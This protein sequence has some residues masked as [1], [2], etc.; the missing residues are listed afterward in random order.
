MWKKRNNVFIVFG[1]FIALVC[2][3]ISFSFPDLFSMYY[4]PHFLFE[5][6]IYTWVNNHKSICPWLSAVWPPLYYYT[7]G[8]YLRIIENFGLFPTHLITVNQCPVFDL[9][10]DKIFL[11]WAKLPFLILHI[12]SAWLFAQFFQHKKTFWFIF[13]LLNPIAIFINFM[14]GQFDSIPTFFLL[15]ALYYSLVKKN[16]YATALALGI[17]GAYKFYPFLL[18]LPFVIILARTMRS[19]AIFLILAITPYI[20]SV[21]PSF[22]KDFLQSLAFSENQKMFESGISIGG[23]HIS[24]YIILYVILL[25]KLLFKKHKTNDLLISY[26]FLFS[27]I[28]FI[29]S[30]WFT[31]RLLF[32]LPSLLLLARTRSAIFKLLPILS[33]LFFLYTLSMFPGLFDHT[34]LRPIL[35]STRNMDY[36]KLPINTI[37]IYIFSTTIGLFLWLIYQA[38]TEPEQ[39]EQIITKGRLFFSAS[40]LVFYLLLVAGIAFYSGSL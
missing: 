30:F 36:A 24:F 6:N 37:Q 4:I 25:L 7:I 27:S 34:L 11:F 2:F 16:I 20:I 1:I 18:V 5:G 9:I 29:T 32:L 15:L 14:E 35:S 8:F 10:N 40:P 31:Q 13:W 33:G 26:S 17:G 19:R 12:A 3:M 21:I 22:N 38:I 28:Y 39:E 23:T